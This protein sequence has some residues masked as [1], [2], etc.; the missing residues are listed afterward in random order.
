MGVV[1]I[2]PAGLG[3]ANTIRDESHRQTVDNLLIKSPEV[4]RT[5]PAIQVPLRG[6]FPNKAK[7][8]QCINESHAD[9]LVQP[10]LILPAGPRPAM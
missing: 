1:S 9:D 4:G 10:V 8:C 5:V 6:Q 2:L 7:A 3:P